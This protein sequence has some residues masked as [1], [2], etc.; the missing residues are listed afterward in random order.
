MTAATSEISCLCLDV[1]GVLT[2][3]R[4]YIDDDGRTLRAFHIHDGLAIAAFRR[5]GGE[6]VICTG[7]R[8]N[9]VVHRA[10]ELGIEHVIQGSH[11]KLD[12]VQP[13]LEKLGVGLNRMAMVGDDLPDLRLMRACGWPIA[14][15]DAVAEV[16]AIARYVTE[17]EGGRGAVREAVEHLLRLNGKW[18]EVVGNYDAET[19]SPG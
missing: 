17:R 2:D 5:L 9:A 3:G 18:N 4:L 10:A 14:V 1:D 13:V 12:D 6:V 15:A 8:S 7:K 19:R 16:K 11:D